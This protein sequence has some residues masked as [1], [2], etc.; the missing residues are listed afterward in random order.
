MI[1]ISY[2]MSINVYIMIGIPITLIILILF[3]VGIILYMRDK[4]KDQIK[5]EV[6][7]QV[8]YYLG[9]IWI[10]IGIVFMISVNVAIGVAFMGL[11][12]SYIA[13]GLANKDKWQ[14]EF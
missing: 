9:F 5:K 10:P 7:Y 1:I 13:I 14:K 2:V 3:L 12:A 4:K 8:F 6:N 11:G